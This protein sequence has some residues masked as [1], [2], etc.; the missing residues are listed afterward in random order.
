MADAVGDELA[1]QQ[2]CVLQDPGRDSP[3]RQWSMTIRAAPGAKKPIGSSISA[4]W[5]TSGADT[6]PVLRPFASGR[7]ASISARRWLFSALSAAAPRR[8]WPNATVNASTVSSR[9]TEPPASGGAGPG[10]RAR[11]FDGGLPFDALFAGM[12]A[13]RGPPCGNRPVA[14]Y[15]RSFHR[16][17][18]MRRRHVG[19]STVVSPGR[20]AAEAPC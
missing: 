15:C 6:P 19:V 3:V 17:R 20:V 5:P 9:R 10:T 4:S 7:K 1:G 12:A 14:V 11:R 2:S 18:R 16:L 8:S 13:L